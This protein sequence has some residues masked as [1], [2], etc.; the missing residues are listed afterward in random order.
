ML[1]FGGLGP[2]GQGWRRMMRPTDRA[3]ERRS[4][5]ARRGGLSGGGGGGLKREEGEVEECERGG[6]ERD[7]YRRLKSGGRPVHAPCPKRGV[8]KP[9]GADRR[10]QMIIKKVIILIIIY[11]KD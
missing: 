3:K 5:G 1:A 11:K 8:A 2:V 6:E 10:P 9:G 7:S 4:E